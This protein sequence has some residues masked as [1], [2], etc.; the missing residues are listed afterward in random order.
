MGA[1]IIDGKKVAKEFRAQLAERV[2]R[3]AARGT[4]PGLTAVLVGDD[5]ASASYV[6]SKKKAA[7]KIGI[8]SNV[9][10]YPADVSQA[11]MNATI[12]R[13]NAD[14]AVHGY[15]VQL[16]LPAHLD[17]DQT[18]HRIAPAKDADC[19]H[20]ENVG[21]MTLGRPRFLPAT[22]AGIIELLRYY[23]IETSGAEVVILGRSNIVGRPLSVMLSRKSQM[24]NATVT[25][26]HTRTR[27]WIDYT[28][29]A[30]ILIAAV[31]RANTVTAEMVKPGATVIDVGMNRL[32]DPAKEKGYRLVGD[33][34]FDPV[35]EIAGYITPVP[36]GV[37]P[38]TVAMLL[39]N[40]VTA[41]EL[42]TK[43]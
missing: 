25:V 16:P 43:S 9:I 22:P 26:C 18:I 35:A 5:P 20:P 4:T 36:G 38:M 14:E 15:I 3:L 37:G 42:I 8:N 32:D 1:Q 33:V 41:A 2:T 31:G 23:K 12:D 6:R 10:E 34:D 24:G 17:V 29:R 11:E 19:F 27:N 21:L 13:L 39:A 7:A 40:T 30:D 28:K